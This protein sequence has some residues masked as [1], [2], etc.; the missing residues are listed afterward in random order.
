VSAA[1]SWLK[2][3]DA[4]P[5]HRRA[6]ADGWEENSTAFGTSAFRLSQFLSS[7]M[8]GLDMHKFEL[9]QYTPK[10]RADQTWFHAIHH[11]D[12]PNTIIEC[13]QVVLRLLAIC[14]NDGKNSRFQGF[15]MDTGV[16]AANAGQAL[17]YTLQ[18]FAYLHSGLDV[19]ERSLDGICRTELQMANHGQ[20]FNSD[21]TVVDEEIVTQWFDQN[22]DPA[23][24]FSITVRQVI[25]N[26]MENMSTKS[27]GRFQPV[28]TDNLILSE[29]VKCN[30]KVFENVSNIEKGA[31]YQN[32]MSA[33][34]EKGTCMGCGTATKR[35][36]AC[37]TVRFCSTLCQ[38]KAWPYHKV[39]CK[40]V[41]TELKK[42]KEMTKKESNK[43]GQEG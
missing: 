42:K 11:P 15:T 2:R 20:M 19:G 7:V 5:N 28:S 36:C 33:R 30:Q 8:M 43:E 12:C 38:K 9:F 22:I 35:K 3:Y 23:A 27:K 29:Y 10:K 39:K 31:L 32:L 26:F 25:A 21:L 24:P 40:Q 18:F 17:T 1:A 4:A 37:K 13:E 6:T 14:L 34:G 41:R 16:M